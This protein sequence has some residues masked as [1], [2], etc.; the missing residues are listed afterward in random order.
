M[1]KPL[2]NKSSLKLGTC[3]PRM[4]RAICVF[5]QSGL[6][7]IARFCNYLDK[8]HMS[9]P[10]CAYLHAQS[11]PGMHSSLMVFTSYLYP[12]FYYS[13]GFIEV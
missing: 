5:E 1:Y 7:S 10:D 6:V 9:R 11:G 3:E 12:E 4:P 13:N 8:L 2:H